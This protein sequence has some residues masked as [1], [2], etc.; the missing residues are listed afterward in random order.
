LRK[1]SGSPVLFAT[2]YDNDNFFEVSHYQLVRVVIARNAVTQFW[3]PFVS[4]GKI[5][6]LVSPLDM[7]ILDCTI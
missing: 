3:Q 6:P 7:A 1:L 4:T 5:L 2:T